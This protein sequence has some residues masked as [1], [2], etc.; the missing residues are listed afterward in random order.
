M[1]LICLLLATSIWVA[2]AEER[3]IPFKSADNLIWLNLEASSGEPLNFLLDSGASVS[4]IDE[5]A[6]AKLKLHGGHPVQVRGVDASTTGRWPLKLEFNESSVRMPNQFL[7]LDLSRLSKRCVCNVDGLLGLDFFKENAIQIDY[8]AKVLRL[9][10]GPGPN[11]RAIPI[12]VREQAILVSLEVNRSKGWFRLDTGCAHPLEWVA[13]VQA[14]GGGIQTRTSIGLA[15]G[16][17]SEI[18]ARVCL[19]GQ[20]FQSVQTGIH[21]ASIFQGENGLL[22]NPFLEQFKVT[23]DLAHSRLFLEPTGIK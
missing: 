4:V 14:K 3:S 10:A 9:N 20:V 12:R 5:T 13:R 8:S 17:V 21:H 2:N 1:R 16:V 15:D 23:F 7:L 6:A 11:A 22:G 18:P 19:A